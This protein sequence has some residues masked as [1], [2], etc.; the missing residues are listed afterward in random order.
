M[1]KSPAFQ[2]YVKDWLSDPQLRLASP[3]TKGIWIDLL[4]YMWSAPEKGKLDLMPENF[5]KL[6]GAKNGDVELFIS[7]AQAYNFCDISVTDNG[8]LQIY[9]RRM[10]REEKDR[11]NNRLR[12][13]RYRDKH[14]RN[15][16]V[17]PLSPTPSPTPTPTTKKKA[18]AWPKDFV[19]TDTLKKY[20]IDNGIH[21][22]KVDAFFD[23]F[24]DW[25]KSKG[26]TYVDWEAAF[27]TRVR[28]APD[29]GKHFMVEN[30]KI[31]EDEKIKTGSD[32]AAQRYQKWK[33]NNL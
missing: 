33:E 16:K 15:A 29:M 26:A 28:K 31:P 3:S 9:N 13:K 12:Q 11:E 19:L 32:L 23:D 25:A 7:E 21:P 27:R 22:D 5:S 1:G 6:T 17:T 8:N 2:F 4:C 18:C 24:H 20:A 10:Y 14:H 30:K